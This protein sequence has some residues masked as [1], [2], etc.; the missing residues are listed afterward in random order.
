MKIVYEW[1]FDDGNPPKRYLKFFRRF[2]WNPETE[3]FEERFWIEHKPNFS[4]AG[5]G[6][7]EA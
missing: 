1:A 6:G 4:I 2:R 7:P 5:R 3:K